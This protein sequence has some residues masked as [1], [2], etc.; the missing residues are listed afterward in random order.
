[1]GLWRGVRDL[2]PSAVKKGVS[3]RN[4]M[5]KA[6]FCVFRFFCAEFHD[7]FFREQ[8]FNM[9]RWRRR[10]AMCFA[11]GPIFGNKFWTP[12]GMKNFISNFWELMFC[13]M[14]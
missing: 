3:F 13:N 7:E 11:S 8:I 5:L 10:S 12:V 9:F 6:V 1:M 2:S 14:S 4:L